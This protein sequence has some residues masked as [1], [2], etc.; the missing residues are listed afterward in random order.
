VAERRFDT[1]SFVAG[2]LALIGAGLF[3]LDDS[4]ALRVDEAV[5]VAALLLALGAVGL[6]RSVGRLARV[7]R[8]RGSS[9][10]STQGT[11]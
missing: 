1:L 7:R 8:A 10:G 4:G 9:D 11:R 5:T 6:V 3:L 2:I